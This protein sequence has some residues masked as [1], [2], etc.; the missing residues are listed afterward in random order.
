MLCSRTLLLL[1]ALIIGSSV[2]AEE[3]VYVD[4][5]QR[6]NLRAEPS[7][8]SEVL[9]VVTS[10]MRL[11]LHGQ[12]DGFV[13]VTTE[14][15]LEGW[16]SDAHVSREEPVRYRLQTVTNERDTLR[17]R[18]HHLESQISSMESEKNAL[19]DMVSELRRNLI[20]AEAQLGPQDGERDEVQEESDGLLAQIAAFWYTIALAPLALI[21][22]GFALGAR[23]QGKRVSKR[24][25]GLRI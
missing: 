16:V 7:L 23:W 22:G 3:F 13:H 25:G 19:R 11:Q 8:R 6:V 10:E 1:C 2:V 4:D 17:E 9:G 18:I 24:L 15:G 14:E 12:R 5:R 20:D 21:L